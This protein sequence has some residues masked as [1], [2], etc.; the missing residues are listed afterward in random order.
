MTGL[1]AVFDVAVNVTERNLSGGL[2]NPFEEKCEVTTVMASGT[3]VG[4]FSP[5]PL[6]ELLYFGKHFITS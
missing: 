6:G 3:A 2:I 1:T 4:T 5:Q